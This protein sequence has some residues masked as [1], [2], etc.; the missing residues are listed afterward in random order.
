[1]DQTE[2]HAALKQLTADDIHDVARSLASDTAGNLY[3]A[4]EAGT[5]EEGRACLIYRST[6]GGEHW[7][8]LF[9]LWGADIITPSIAIAEGPVNALFVAFEVT[10]TQTIYVLR[11]NLHD[12]SLW[13]L[14]EIM[15]N[16]PGVSNPRI[17]VDSAEYW[18]WY[19]YV[20]YNAMA[21]DN[22][23]FLH[24]RTTEIALIGCSGGKSFS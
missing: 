12:P 10:N 23:V 21:V 9:I 16:A 15:T 13:D 4:F 14:T 24:T 2:F 22:W 1:M 8:D 5:E 17:A 18:V 11:V 3:A 7:H 19:A 20:V 6:D